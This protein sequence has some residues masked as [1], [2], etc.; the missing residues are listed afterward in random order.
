MEAT[1]RAMETQYRHLFE[2]NPQPM[3]VYD[4]DTLKFLAVNEAAIR[5]YGYSRVELLSMTIKDTCPP[6]DTPELLKRVA[7][8][9]ESLNEPMVWRQLKKDGTLIDMEV[10]SEGLI[11][12]GRC[13]ALV[14]ATDVTERWRAEAALRASEERLKSTMDSMLEGG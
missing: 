12:D 7:Q 3:W 1:F 9:T 8:L 4:L 13:A 2:S 5:Q 14:M 11:F 10:R 6:E